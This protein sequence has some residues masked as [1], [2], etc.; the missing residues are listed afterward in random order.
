M[1]FDGGW[2][3][4]CNV[5]KNKTYNFVVLCRKISFYHEGHEMWNAQKSHMA[6]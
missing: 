6:P 2:H 3:K 5:Q 4:P 1:N